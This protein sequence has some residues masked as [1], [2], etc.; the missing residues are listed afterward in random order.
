MIQACVPACI[1][2]DCK[3]S[4]FKLVLL[5][6]GPHSRV[7]VF[8][9]VALIPSFDSTPFMHVQF[10]HQALFLTCAWFSYSPLAPIDIHSFWIHRRLRKLVERPMRITC[11]S[12]WTRYVDGDGGSRKR[13]TFVSWFVPVRMACLHQWRIGQLGLQGGIRPS[14]SSRHAMGLSRHGARKL[15]TPILWSSIHFISP[16]Q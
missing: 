16:L 10:S 14:R 11:F 7:A 4:V 15:S 12:P 13:K 2:L 9:K 6:K 3:V 1:K 8:T 5:Y